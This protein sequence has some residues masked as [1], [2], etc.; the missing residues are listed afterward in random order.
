M[1]GFTRVNPRVQFT[2]TIAT[3][4]ELQLSQITF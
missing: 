2:P 3:N 1:I 4:T